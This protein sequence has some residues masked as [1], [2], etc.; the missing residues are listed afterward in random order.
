M[1]RRDLCLMMTHE[2]PLPATGLRANAQQ[3]ALLVLINAFVG[4][5]VGL[6]R[7]VLP[8]LAG[9]VFGIAS[10]TAV[11]SFILAF[12]VSKAVFN[13]FAGRWADRF[14][15]KRLL[16]AGWLIGLPVP[17]ILMYAP[18]WDWVVAANILL[19]IHQGLA[20]S[21]TV[22]MKIDLA[23][24][25][26]RGLAMGLNEFAG[27]LAVGV[28]AF[29]TGWI[30][31]E[32]GVRPWPFWLGAGI[33]VAG[34]LSTLLWVRDTHRHVEAAA[35]AATAPLLPQVF[36]DT[37]LRHPNLGAVT[38]AGLVNNLNDG[39]LWGLLPL[40]L[41]ARA[42]DAG[43]IGLVAAVYPAVWGIA[44]LFTGKLAD[45]LPKKHLITTGMSLQGLAIAG[46]TFDWNLAGYVV[47]AG[48]LGL[49]TALV[50]PTFLA[51]VADNTHPRQRAE[52]LGVFRFWRDLGYAAGALVA[53]LTA[54][55]LG[56]PAAFWLVAGLT[57]AA[58][59]V[60]RWR[61]G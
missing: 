49:G 40:L 37:T 58:G 12:G 30:A 57:L 15:R 32:Y 34:L 19:G 54:D 8:L 60:A 61:M 5:M 24:E 7:S 9:E 10:T 55:W 39:M 43:S 14:G 42:F 47:L 31:V 59:W 52:S 51:V 38:L 50:Y 28:V 2:L 1:P 11:F 53:G 33:A 20:W 17:F 56:L 29:A 25:K 46:L 3:F 41:H 45:H 44:Q 6:E 23:G 27:Y 26:E 21:S 4:G 35:Q 16:V 48:L 13:Y 22:I 36:W 18:S